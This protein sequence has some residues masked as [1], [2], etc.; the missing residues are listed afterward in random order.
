MPEQQHLDLRKPVIMCCSGPSLR[1]VDV[2]APGLPVAVV[3]TAIRTV[4]GPDYWIF[5]DRATHKHGDEGQFACGSPKIRKIMP[6]GRSKG[7]KV[8]LNTIWVGVTDQTKSRKRSFMDG[9]NPPIITQFKRSSLF[10]IQWLI[11]EGFNDIIFAGC[12][13]SA[14]REDPYSYKASMVEKL[15]RRQNQGHK[16]ELVQLADWTKIAASK[17][18]RFLSWSPGSVI[19]RFMEPFDEHERFDRDDGT[20]DRTTARVGSDG[21]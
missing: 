4:P 20:V 7:C 2:F 5:V 16:R 14:S 17:G 10:A 9:G 13:L 19:N 12:D 21:Y 6:S 3:S 15:L 8:Y 18:V 11:V 1:K